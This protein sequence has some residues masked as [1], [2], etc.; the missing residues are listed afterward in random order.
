MQNL[1]RQK[2]ETLDNVWIRIFAF[3]DIANR[4][5]SKSYHDITA[6]ELKQFA[7]PRLL[8]KIDYRNKLPSP[9]KSN[10]LSIL[11]IKNGL[12]RIAKTD[13]F[14]SINLAKLDKIPI[15]SRQL[16][17][18]I[19]TIDVSNISSESQAL[20]AAVASGMIDKL[21]GE[22]SYLT[23]RG[24]RYTSKMNIKIQRQDSKVLQNYPISSVQI[25]VDGGYESKSS[26]ALIEAKMGTADNMNMRQLVYPHIHFTNQTKKDVKTFVMFYETGSIF[27]FIPM[28]FE[29]N[30]PSLDYKKA[31]RFRLVKTNTPKT[32][33]STSAFTLPA[34]GNGAPFPQADDFSKVLFGLLKLSEIQPASKADLFGNFPLDPRQYDYYFNA[35]RWLGLADQN[36]R[37]GDCYLTS[38]G[39]SLI[40]MNEKQRI[41]VIREIMLS[42]DVF[43]KALNN[44]QYE[45]TI[46]ELSDRNM[47]AK[48]Y[49]NR[50]RNT[51]L[52]WL[53]ETDKNPR[54]D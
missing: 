40:E 54:L 26:L 31:V 1:K 6:E 43:S 41:S 25:E 49:S 48:T 20:D 51:V 23:V 4:V 13:P 21:L 33:F 39:N 22:E 28:V 12:Y 47:S 27:T 16:P 35:L 5:K 53:N 36:G 3:Y 50:R 34:T 19:T 45:P 8:C 42:D 15:L 14:F 38:I 32:I 52:S 7:E 29:S 37:G 9:F 11:A 44:H 10:G 2:G 24:R 30:N 17:S 46:K 18:F